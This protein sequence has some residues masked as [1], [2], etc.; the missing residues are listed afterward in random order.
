[1]P[2]NL[3]LVPLACMKLCVSTFNCW[4]CPLAALVGKTLPT[5][6]CKGFQNLY[7]A[8]ENSSSIKCS[9][10]TSPATEDCISF[11][12]FSEEDIFTFSLIPC[13]RS[14]RVTVAS[15]NTGQYFIDR[16]LTTAQGARILPYTRTDNQSS[17]S[18]AG[19]TEDF[20]N[21]SLINVQ[22]NKTEN[23]Y[24]IF[25]LQSTAGLYFPLTPIPLKCIGKTTIL[26]ISRHYNF[27]NFTKL[28]DNVWP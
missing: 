12:C 6:V 14:I 20:L 1:M 13:N 11:S 8:L 18:I 7:S 22:V 27:A 5:T 16:T 25:G 24:Y 17:A 2:F 26:V 28:E 19:S 23:R 10:T 4:S 21:I 15:R 3:P 9:T